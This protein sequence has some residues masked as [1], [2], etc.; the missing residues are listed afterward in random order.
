VPYIQVGNEGAA[1]FFV[2]APAAA[3]L[4]FALAWR[5]SWARALGAVLVVLV[6]WA[7]WIGAIVVYCGVLDHSCFD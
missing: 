3:T 5:Q 1:A 6:S 4:A 2:I 7:S